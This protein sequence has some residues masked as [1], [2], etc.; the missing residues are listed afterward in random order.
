M[1]WQADRV[2]GGEELV[3]ELWRQQ[4]IWSQTANRMKA[5]IGRAR[6]AALTLTVGGAMVATLAAQL[7]AGQNMVRSVLV[8]AAAVGLGLVPVLR[9]RYGGR[10]LRDW[11]RARSVSEALKSEV[12]L[13]L[14][15]VGDYRGEN[16]DSRLKTRTDRVC[17][18]AA[19]LLRHTVEIEP[20][21]RPMPEVHDYRSYLR[22]RVEGQVA[23]YY[24]PQA[25]QLRT[26]LRQFRRI[27]L[28]LSAAGVV[29]GGLAASLAEWGLSAW[30]A[31]VTTISASVAAHVAAARYEYQLIEYLRTADE[32][33]R[34]QRDASATAS[35]AEVDE[36]VVR[37]ERIIS[38]QN[39]G[40]MAKLSSTP[41]EESKT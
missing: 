26:R 30:I 11:T 10:V 36:L 15:G 13:Y 25:R 32:L 12:Y 17:K 6:S 31:L 9:P 8:V 33:S 34:L 40:W 18:E 24:R 29:L 2:S 35:P 14:A 16:R 21:Q 37:C 20:A 41:E 4:S 39:E 22:V 5:S 28:V 27:E 3:D 19:D 1:L 23:G 7:P 38:I